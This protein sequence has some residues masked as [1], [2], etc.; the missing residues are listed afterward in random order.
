MCFVICAL[1][2]HLFLALRRQYRCAQHLLVQVAFFHHLSSTA[3]INNT[4]Y[5]RSVDSGS[6]SNLSEKGVY[7]G[8]RVSV[9]KYCAHKF[10]IFT[11]TNNALKNQLDNAIN[12]NYIKDLKNRVMRFA[13]RSTKNTR[14]YLYQTYGS[15]TL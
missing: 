13:T 5:L 15:V 3:L 4:F 9:P 14:Q 11:A 6:Y 10:R 2:L 12:A 1:L 8:D 7:L